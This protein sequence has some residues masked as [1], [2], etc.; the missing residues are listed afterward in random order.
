MLKCIW[1]PAVL[2]GYRSI[3][4]FHEVPVVS[5]RGIINEFLLTEI[6]MHHSHD[7]SVNLLPRLF[8][9]ISDISTQHC[10][11][12]NVPLVAFSVV[13]SLRVH[14]RTRGLKIFSFEDLFVDVV[15]VPTVF[16]HDNCKL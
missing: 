10:N 6:R 1:S 11:S 13:L 5:F 8:G 7:D 3:T 12:F 4:L 14:A 16:S 15:G 9:V 2:R